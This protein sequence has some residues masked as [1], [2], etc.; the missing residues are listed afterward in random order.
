MVYGRLILIRRFCKR[1]GGMS[2]R[3]ILVDTNILIYLLD[4]NRLVR[5]VLQ[6]RI[7]YISFITELELIGMRPIGSNEQFR[8]RALLSDLICLP[9]NSAIKNQ[10]QWIRGKHRLMLPDAVIAATSLA[11]QL[12][13]FSADKQ[14]RSVKELSLIE[15]L[16]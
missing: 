15:H 6:N 12:P 1:I 10:Y 16:T 14:F 13:F 2:G 5:D 3:E 9:L 8:V 4:G 7:V 11:Y